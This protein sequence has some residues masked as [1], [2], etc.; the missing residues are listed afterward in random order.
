MSS[1][2]DKE[3]FQS[4]VEAFD[5]AVLFKDKK[6][7]YI[8]DNSN[9]GVF[10]SQIQFDLSTLSSQSN[11][12]SLKEAVIQFPIKQTIKNTGGGS[13]TPSRCAIQSAALKNGFHQMVDSIQLVID[14]QTVQTSQI[15]KNIE[16]QFKILK[17]W[18]KDTEAKYGTLT[19]WGMDRTEIN[20]SETAVSLGNLSLSTVAPSTYGVKNDNTSASMHNLGVKERLEFQNINASN[21]F[22]AT[23][24]GSSSS[25]LGKNVVDAAAS[26]TAQNADCFCQFVLATIRLRD[27]CPF[28]EEMPLTRNLRGFLYVNYNAASTR[29]IS[30]ASN[31]VTSVAHSQIYGRTHPGMLRLEDNTDSQSFWPATAAA[32]DWTLTTEISGIPSA[33]KTAAIP[34][35]T[36]ARLNVPYYNA[37]PTIDSILSQKKT[38]RYLEYQQSEFDL[39]ANGSKTVTLSPG[40]AG[41]KDVLLVPY[42]TTINGVTVNPWNSS[43]DSA[44]A[45]SS[46]MA[47]LRDL[48]VLVGNVPVFNNPVTMDADMFLQEISKN[49][50]EGGQVNEL[51]SGLLS[52]KLWNEWYRYYYV[53]VGRRMDTDD[54]CSRS[55]IVQVTNATTLPMK[56][57]AFVHYEKEAT[58]DCNTGQVFTG[59]L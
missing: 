45:T 9:G 16:T 10:Q 34:P 36:Y 41:V 35:L 22:Q 27:I 49:G 3:V 57:L 14:G 39:A 29:V 51:S 7:T 50:I 40:I 15:F 33:N 42:Y 11:W 47:T 58:L 43:F 1:N 46:P 59:R 38:F 32:N 48:Q 55:V 30:N 28:V 2:S 6:W 56:V 13:Q 12:V 26:A 5:N 37:N 23:V 17:D 21:D 54:G 25:V 19:G 52:Q 44:P 4:T 31:T 8:T 24:L 20:T 18:S 53:D